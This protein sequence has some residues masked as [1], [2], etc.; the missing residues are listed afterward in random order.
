MSC[1]GAAAAPQGWDNWEGHFNKSFQ[2]SFKRQQSNVESVWDMSGQQLSSAQNLL[3]LGSAQ[4][5]FPTTK[6]MHHATSSK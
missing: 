4:N 6:I 2:E 3:Q 1:V 5:S